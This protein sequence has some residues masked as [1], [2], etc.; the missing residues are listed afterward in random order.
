MIPSKKSKH[1]II[2]RIELQLL[3][4]DGM[5]P[6]VFI[7]L[8]SIPGIWSVC[9]TRTVSEIGDIIAFHSSDVLAKYAGLTWSKNDSG[10]FVFED[11]SVPKTENIYL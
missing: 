1:Y 8:K 11:N 2:R 4:F 5:D 3:F 7:I 9:A 10:N 6:N